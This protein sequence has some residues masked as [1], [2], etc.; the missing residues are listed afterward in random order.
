MLLSTTD[1]LLI[2]KLQNTHK[3]GAMNIPYAIEC[4]DG[5]YCIDTND[6]YKC[7]A[8]DVFNLSLIG[9]E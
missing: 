5:D 4:A 3:C 2:A 7:K 9:R 1:P 8:L 6:M